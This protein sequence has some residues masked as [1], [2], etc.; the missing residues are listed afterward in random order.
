MH[1][2]VAYHCVLKESGI[3]CHSRLRQEYINCTM[4]TH[5]TRIAQSEHNVSRIATVEGVAN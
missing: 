4:Y 5:I 2:F 1:R 3:K